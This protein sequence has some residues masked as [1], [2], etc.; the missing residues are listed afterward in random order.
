MVC[1]RVCMCV[2]VCVCVCRW[3]FKIRRSSTVPCKVMSECK[4]SG[5]GERVSMLCQRVCAVI[6][7]TRI[8]QD[9]VGDAQQIRSTISVKLTTIANG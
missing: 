5:H 2:C 4:V 1:T 9:Q 3:I 6:G 7:D 8:L